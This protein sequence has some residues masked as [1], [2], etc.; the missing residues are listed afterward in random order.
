MKNKIAKFISIITVVPIIAAL[1]VSWIY[2]DSSYH[3]CIGFK[4][5]ALSIFFLTILPISAYVIKYAIPSIMKQ[6][7][8]GERKLAF[9]MAV[10]GYIIGTIVCFV[11]SAPKVIKIVFLSYLA[12]GG[13]L[14]LVNALSKFKASGHA[15]GVAGPITLLVSL[16]GNLAWITVLIIPFVYWA[17]ISLNRHKVSEL[18]AGTAFGII[19]TGLV[20]FIGFKI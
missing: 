6:G 12:S 1:A 19:A 7:R 18:I 15:C 9:I 8:K 10:A 2:F 14:A 4:W 13:L 3:K 11:F 16:V 5:Y 17:R 20:V